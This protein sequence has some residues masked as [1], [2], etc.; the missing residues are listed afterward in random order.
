M[1]K[2]LLVLVLFLFLIIPSYSS[3][4]GEVQ[5]DF[6]SEYSK[7]TDSATGA[8]IPFAEIELPSLNYKTTADA[9]G[10]FK[11][12]AQI[13][14]PTVLSV[15]KD[16]YKPFS[17][18]VDK[19]AMAN[20]LIIGIDKSSLK[21]MSIE[22]GLIHI[23]DDNY[24][25]NSANAGDFRFRSVGPFYTKKF[26]IKMHDGA[27]DAYFVIGSLIGL[28]TV[29][30]QRQG[31]SKVKSTYATPAQVYFNGQLISEIKLN[32]DGIEI[33]LPRN[34]IKYNSM[35]EITLQAGRNAF[36]TDSIDYDDIEVTNLSVDV[37]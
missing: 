21:S 27:T 13:N 18:T 10:E 16:G 8:A 32:G 25:S 1:K 14:S 15:K 7:I 35:N 22:T 24:S 3:I 31:I 17:I 12:S 36:K 33:K 4:R 9:N 29:E 5:K 11:L 23:G 30:S 26:N 34:L 6:F 37:R 19:F 28:D 20:P 2:I